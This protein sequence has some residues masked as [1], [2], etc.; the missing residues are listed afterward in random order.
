MRW[1]LKLSRLAFICNIC[2]VLAFTLQ[3][4]NWIK[5]QDLSGTILIIGYFMVVLFN[6]LV[7]ICYLVLFLIRKKFWTTVPPW[8]ITANILFLV[9]QL[10]FILYLNDQQHP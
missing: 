5:D 7:N 10:F 1:L 6:P 3:I 2:F 8:L 9:M 4:S